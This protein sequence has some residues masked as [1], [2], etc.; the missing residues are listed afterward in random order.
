MNIV[1]CLDISLYKY[2]I[3]FYLPLIR[4]EAGAGVITSAS[5]Q[6]RQILLP[7]VDIVGGHSVQ[8]EDA[9]SYYHCV[10]IRD[11]AGTAVIITSTI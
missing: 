6:R 8:S 4:P 11:G 3:L 10:H 2:K 9:P 5:V 7:S 1:I